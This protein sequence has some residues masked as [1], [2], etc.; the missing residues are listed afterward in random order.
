MTPKQVDEDKIEK[1]IEKEKEERLKK[2]LR[3]SSTR[4]TCWQEIRQADC[5]AILPQ[6]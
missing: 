6:W 3:L 4:G 5:S 1:E 2:E